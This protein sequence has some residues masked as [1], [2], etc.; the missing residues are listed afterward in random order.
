MSSDTFKLCNM[1]IRILLDIF[2]EPSRIIFLIRLLILV[3]NRQVYLEKRMH[4]P[5]TGADDKPF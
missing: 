4:Q 1:F 3:R 5:V 2:M